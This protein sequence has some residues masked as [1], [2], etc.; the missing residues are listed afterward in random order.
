MVL[1]CLG[2]VMVGLVRFGIDLWIYLESPNESKILNYRGLGG[3]LAGL[4]CGSIFF[5]LASKKLPL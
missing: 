3:A 2:M 1:L 5:Y 4:L